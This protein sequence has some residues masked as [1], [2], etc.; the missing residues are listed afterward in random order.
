MV[1]ILSFSAKVKEVVGTPPPLQGGC[2]F[3]LAGQNHELKIP[4]DAPGR[5]E[6]FAMVKLGL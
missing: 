3:F 4:A 2:D 6:A 5:E 1:F